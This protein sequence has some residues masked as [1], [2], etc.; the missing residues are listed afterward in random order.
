M[1]VSQQPAL[2]RN[3]TPNM[4]GFYSGTG[5]VVK[6]ISKSETSTSASTNVRTLDKDGNEAVQEIV[7]IPEL[8]I[9]VATVSI[10]DNGSEGTNIDV[11]EN[12]EH[13]SADGH[14]TKCD[15][16]N[17]ISTEGL[18]CIGDTVKVNGGDLE[19]N[20]DD[21]DDDDDSGWITPDN[22][23]IAC[24]EM[25]GVLNERA[26]GIAVGCTTTDFAMQVCRLIERE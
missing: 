6:D 12:L 24:E 7:A 17:G 9:L 22:F 18:E 23:R 15:H 14:V 3:K 25:G 8:E 13:A 19:W 20:S 2:E 5:K 26:T 16:I 21:N 11:K 10:A 1:S 4:V